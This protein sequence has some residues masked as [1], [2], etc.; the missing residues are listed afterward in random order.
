M[1]KSNFIQRLWNDNDGFLTVKSEQAYV[2]AEPSMD[3][4]KS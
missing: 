3:D 1:Y 4:R 2:S